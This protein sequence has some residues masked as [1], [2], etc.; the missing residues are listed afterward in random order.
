MCLCVDH[1]TSCYHHASRN[2]NLLIIKVAPGKDISHA[3]LTGEGGHLEEKHLGEV[4]NPNEERGGAAQQEVQALSE[5]FGR[6]CDGGTHKHTSIQACMS[7]G[8]HIHMCACVVSWCATIYHAIS[9]Y[10]PL[11]FFTF[12]M[13]CVMCLQRCLAC[14]PTSEE[15]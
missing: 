9:Y 14:W 10:T 1:S 2:I 5:A 13:S 11:Y 6:T 15:T 7:I 4:H 3:F 12:H 8:I